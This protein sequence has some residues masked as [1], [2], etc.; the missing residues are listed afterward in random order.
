MTDNA[1]RALHDA[2]GDPEAEPGELTERLDQAAAPESIEELRA[3]ILSAP[4]DGTTSY[5]GCADACARLILEAWARWPQL[6]ELP[7]ED[8]LLQADG[9]MVLIDNCPVI[10]VHGLYDALK[11]VYRD[12]PDAQSVFM[13]LTGFMW[14]WAF[15]AA[16]RCIDQPPAPNPALVT[17][18]TP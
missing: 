5:E 11:A 2:F 1:D 6:L 3:R 15:N 17:I 10:V 18:S 9:K 7:T 16:L 13:E 8:V 14:G 12:R 4:I